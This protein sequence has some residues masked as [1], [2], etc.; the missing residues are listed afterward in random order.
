MTIFWTL[1]SIPELASLP[2]RDRRVYWRRAYRRSWRHWQTWA[3]LLACAI[4]AGLGSGLG[5]FLVHP[6]VGA[7]IGGNVGGFV[8]AQTTVRVARLHYKNVLLGRDS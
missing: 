6:I 7:T 8:F 4:C 5:A 3:S 2:A 1:K